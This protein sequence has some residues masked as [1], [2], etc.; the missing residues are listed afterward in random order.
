MFVLFLLACRAPVAPR[1]GQDIEVS[2]LVMLPTG[3]TLDTRSAY[4][5]NIVSGPACESAIEMQRRPEPW[6]SS[7]DSLMIDLVA[8][9]HSSTDSTRS[10]ALRW[11]EDDVEW[12]MSGVT[13]Q[14]LDHDGLATYIAVEGPVCTVVQRYA[15]CEEGA[16]VGLALLGILSTGRI[17]T[18]SNGEPGRFTSDSG[19][20]LCQR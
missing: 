11:V 9:A 20:V 8:S 17:S 10:A 13:T 6:R 4:P 16:P 18:W 2:T 5:P 3:S 12:Q 19:A 1:L 14:V 15:T 7:S